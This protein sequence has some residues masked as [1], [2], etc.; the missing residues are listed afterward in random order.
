MPLGLGHHLPHRAGPGS[1][2]GLDVEEPDARRADR[3]PHPGSCAPTTWKPAH[4]ASTTAPLRHPPHEG[5]VVDERACGAHLRPVLAP[6]QAVDVRLGQGLVG[7]G[8]QQLGV[9]AAPL[10]APGQD[11]PVAAVAVGPE[12]VGVHHRHPQRPA[13]AGA[14]RRSWNAV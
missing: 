5:A 3:R 13:H 12:Q 7:R 1:L 10:R 8:L 11:Q 2:H 9:V 6:A 14:P 4:T